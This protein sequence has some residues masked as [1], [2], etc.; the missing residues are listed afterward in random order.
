MAKRK[1]IYRLETEEETYEFEDYDEALSNLATCAFYNIPAK[2]FHNNREMTNDKIAKQMAYWLG[3][4]HKRFLNFNAWF[5]KYSAK[6]NP[7]FE[8]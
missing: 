5:E 2:L 8:A 1:N 3:F 6:P 4:H 7:K